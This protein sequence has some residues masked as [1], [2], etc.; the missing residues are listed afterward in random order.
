MERGWGGGG[1]GVETRV[2]CGVSASFCDGV[3]RKKGIKNKNKKSK[4]WGRGGEITGNESGSWRESAGKAG[5]EVAALTVRLLPPPH[6]YQCRY[7]LPMQ[8]PN[9]PAI[10]QFA[11]PHEDSRLSTSSFS[12]THIYIWRQILFPPERNGISLSL[13]HYQTSG[14][15]GFKVYKRWRG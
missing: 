13:S 15:M 12:L 2:N 5:S 7:P 8:P 4:G 3:W 6:P 10:G 14:D 9:A 1:G 11:G